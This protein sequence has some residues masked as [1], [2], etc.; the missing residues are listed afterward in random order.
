MA[1]DELSP[2]L[3]EV[4]RAINAE[5][6]VESIFK[7]L[8]HAGANMD[9]SVKKILGNSVFEARYESVA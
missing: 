3:Q 6:N 9:H 7:I 2:E 4:A 1:L 8:E 5:E